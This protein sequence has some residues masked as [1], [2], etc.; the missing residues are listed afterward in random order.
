MIAGFVDPRFA[1]V[2]EAFA[3]CFADGID[4]GGAVCAVVDGRVVADLWGGHADAA[5]TRPWRRDTLVNVWSVT[6]GIVALAVAMLV[7]QGK[8]DYAAPI[9]SVWPEFAANGKD[10]IPLDLVMSH[11][12]GL[13]GTAAPITEAEVDEFIDGTVKSLDELAVQLRREK[14]TVVG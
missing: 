6:K 1:G 8:L 11:R 12:A 2:R 14:I 13:N 5:R 4:H 9:A 7:E 10:S 3:S